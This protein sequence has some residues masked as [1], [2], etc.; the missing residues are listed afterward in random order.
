MLGLG[1]G[2]NPQPQQRRRADYEPGLDDLVVRNLKQGRLQFT[3]DTAQAIGHGDVIFI[4]VG[5]PP[6][7]DG[8]ADLSYALKA[9]SDIGRWMRSDKVVVNKST[10][11]VGTAERVQAAIASELQQRGIDLEGSDVSKGNTRL[12][13]A[14]VSNPEFLKEGAAIADFL[15]PDRVVIG[16]DSARAILEMRALY[17]PFTRNRERLIVMDQRSAELTKYA[18]NAMLATT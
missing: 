7:E 8:S 13:C 4:A 9:A 6:Q 1:S 14:V 17:E 5:T 10:V 3:T 12:R 2:Q 15:K 11:P 18:A 16:S